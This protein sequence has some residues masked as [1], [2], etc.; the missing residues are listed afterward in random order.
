MSRPIYSVLLLEDDEPLRGVL[1][2]LL[3]QWGCRVYATSFGQDAIQMA[4]KVHFD[5]SLLDMHL[6]GMSGYEVLHFLQTEI[7]PLPSI[8]MSGEASSVE[9]R[10]AL[11][12]GAFTF[13]RKPLDL[14]DLRATMDQLIEFHFGRQP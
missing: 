12:L 11:E 7:V 13:L 1:D 2:E 3:V 9:T 4:Q 6:P 5:F 8:M 14:Q 10:R